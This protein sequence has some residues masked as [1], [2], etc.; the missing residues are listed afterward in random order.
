MRAVCPSCEDAP[1]GERGLTALPGRRPEFAAH[2]QSVFDDAQALQCPL[3]HVMAGTADGQDARRTFVANMTL[4][5][6]FTADVGAELTLE[7]LTDR[8]NPGY[9]LTQCFDASQRAS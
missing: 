7:P 1:K 4:A 3:I 8:N 6:Q 9:F 5:A 2:I